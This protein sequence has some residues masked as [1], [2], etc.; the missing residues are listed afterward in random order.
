M[1]F[2]LSSALGLSPTA[3]FAIAGA[4]ILAAALLALRV[5]LR[6]HKPDH[7]RGIRLND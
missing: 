3:A 6:G 7:Q 4:G 1:G 2:D 5:Y